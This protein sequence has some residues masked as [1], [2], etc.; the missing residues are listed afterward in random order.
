MQS[1]LEWIES[2]P[3]N[4]FVM[5]SIW[6][7]PAAETIHFL[8]LILLFGSLAIVD[9]RLLG[10]ARSIPLRA[11]TAFVPVSIIGFSLNLVTGLLF[12]FG[13]PFRYFPNI[14]FRLKMLAIILAG[15]NAVWY[16]MA[17]DNRIERGEP[18]EM[19]AKVIAAASL[20][21]WI[22]VIVAGRMIPYVE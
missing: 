5:D 4:A 19:S 13:D 20:I 2:S 8:G 16:K 3:L 7:F 9:L 11:V 17:V 6:V 10:V 1:V 14:G 21:I 18:L 22:F 15:L 12:I